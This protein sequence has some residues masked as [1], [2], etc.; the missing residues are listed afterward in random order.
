[1]TTGQSD[2]PEAAQRRLGEGAFSSGLS[3]NDF[4]ACLEMGL[5]PV[6]LVQGFCA[7]QWGSYGVGFMQRGMTPYGG[8]QGGYVENY[9]CPHVGMFGGEHRMWGQNYQQTWIETAWNEGFSSAYSR[10]LEEAGDVHAD[11]IV[12]VVDSQS[13][14]TEAG[15]IEFHLTGTAVKLKGAPAATTPPWTTY[16]AGARLAKLFEAGF[17]PV[18]IIANVSSI[19]VWAYCMTEYL[20]G[21]GGAFAVNQNFAPQEIDQIVRAQ[22]AARTIAR[23]AV[24]QQLHGDSLHGADLSVMEREFEGGDLEVQTLLRGNRVRRFKA[25]E[26]LPVPQPTVRLS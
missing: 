2:L 26:A 3:V 11:G 24:H 22:I 13:S 4:A 10:M 9:Q 14:L 25:F 5:E 8:A 1:M 12:G 15:I 23:K 7:M 18:S 20:M 17:A 6:G 19:R 16:L 21:G